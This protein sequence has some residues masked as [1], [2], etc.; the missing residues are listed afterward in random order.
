MPYHRWLTS[1][2]QTFMS[3]KFFNFEKQKKIFAN[4]FSRFHLLYILVFFSSQFKHKLKKCWWCTLEL[5]QGPQD[6][7]HAGSTELLRTTFL[8]SAFAVTSITSGIQTHDRDSNALTMKI[9]I[10]GPERS[11][12]WGL[13]CSSP[14]LDNCRYKPSRVEQA[15]FLVID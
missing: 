8:Y 14:I 10:R 1:K 2:N 12:K 4:F 5:N 3:A 7:S 6:G 11:L 15:Y 9:K 13:I